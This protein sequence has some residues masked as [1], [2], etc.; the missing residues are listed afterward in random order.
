MGL[1]HDVI[2]GLDS[3]PDLN[4]PEDFATSISTAY[5]TDLAD[6]GSSAAAKVQSLSD[7]RDAALAMVQEL[8]VQNFDL[9]MQLGAGTDVDDLEAD[10]N[11]GGPAA[12]DAE[13]ADSGIA[14]LFE[15]VTDDNTTEE[16]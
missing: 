5:D 15:T 12:T 4:V 14:S 11:A 1:F 2:G 8:K 7:E 10:A 13:D 16:K 6:A 9:V 3:H